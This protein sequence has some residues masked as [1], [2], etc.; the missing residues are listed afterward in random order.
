MLNWDDE[1]Q[2]SPLEVEQARQI[3]IAPLDAAIAQ[4]DHLLA[5]VRRLH[6][7]A[8]REQ[9]IER[10]LA[11]REER[12]AI[13]R[14]R[15]AE[16]D[17]TLPKDKSIVLVRA[18]ELQAEFSRFDDYRV[19]RREGQLVGFD[20]NKVVAYLLQPLF[21]AYGVRRRTCRLPFSLRRGLPTAATRGLEFV[22]GMLRRN[23]AGRLRS[24]CVR[25]LRSAHAH[26]FAN[27]SAASRYRI[28][29]PVGAPPLGLLIRS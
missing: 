7:C 8:E 5:S 9:L 24:G 20:P 23:A 2:L 4:A 16:L 10:V 27:R 29:A 18:D 19:V 12:L 28:L 25:L 26:A 22:V 21:G 17:R 14:E 6:A 1:I 13:K 15:L 3:A 11:L